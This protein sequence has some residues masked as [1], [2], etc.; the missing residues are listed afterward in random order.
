MAPTRQAEPAFTICIPSNRPLAEAR[1]AILS[2]VAVI[3]E[4][5]AE[6]V[7]SDNSGDE[8]KARWLA[9]L[10]TQTGERLRVLPSPGVDATENWNRCVQAARGGFAGFLSDDDRLQCLAPPALDQPHEVVGLRPNIVIWTPG[11]GALHVS[12]FALDEG[13]A[14]DRITAYMARNGGNNTTY[15]S[16]VRREV[17]QPLFALLAAESPSRAGF[18]D[19]AIVIALVSSGRFLAEPGLV[20]TY[21]N[22][23]WSGDGADISKRVRMLYTDAGLPARA[24]EFGAA[25]QALDAYIL[26][27]RQCSPVAA[28]ERFAAATWALTSLIKPLIVDVN[29]NPQAFDEAEIRLAERLALASSP[30]ALLGALLRVVAHFEPGLM[31]RYLRFHEAA[32]GAPWGELPGRGW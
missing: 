18:T 6:V 27:A 29:R 13:V 21:C 2:A 19:W 17:L 16:L 7:V 32:I 11:A 22:Q 26:I 14:Q 10:A 30:E 3:E 4:A 24:A 8:A 31:A 12:R 9:R 23:N 20:L 15:Y 28:E 5:D 25:F 1:A